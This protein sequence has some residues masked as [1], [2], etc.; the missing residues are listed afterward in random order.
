MLLTAV[1]YAGVHR[2]VDANVDGWRAGYVLAG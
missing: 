1:L 2:D